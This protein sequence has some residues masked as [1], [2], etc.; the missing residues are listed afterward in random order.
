MSTTHYSPTLTNAWRSPRLIYRAI[1]DNP[2]DRH[3]LWTFFD[4]DPTSIAMASLRPLN[5]QPLAFVQRLYEHAHTLHI[6]VF[7]CL[8]PSD[9][10]IVQWESL[11]LEKAE[12]SGLTATLDVEKLKTEFPRPGP[13][14]IGVVTLMP[15]MGTEELHH[16]NAMIGVGIGAEWRGKGYGGEAV[17][18]VL[19]Y[20]F[21]R[22]GLHRIWLAAFEYNERACR[23]YRNLGF[24][25]EGREREAVLYERKWWDML[26]FSM[27]EG[28]WEALR[29][30]QK[31]EKGE[32]CK[33]EDGKMEE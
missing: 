30:R 7:I 1:E 10:D 27:L 25:E 24:V 6:R 16:R 3:T 21:G 32:K 13:T 15:P 28:E 9:S 14:P 19:D 5:P 23:L 31:E 26:R 11:I 20:G 22:L 33:G 12:K 17:D 29:V 4:N 2:V 8:P 18:W